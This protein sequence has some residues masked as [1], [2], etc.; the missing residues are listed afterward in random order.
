MNILVIGLGVIGSIYGYAFA[1]AGHTVTHYLRKDSKKNAINAL[2]IN[3]LDG[4]THKKGLSYTDTYPIGHATQKEYD[5]IFVAVPSGKLG[6]VI[7]ELNREGITG[8]LLIACGIWEERAEVKKILGNRPYVLGYPVA[9]GNLQ[10]KTL[11]ACLFDHFMLE[12][13]AKAGIPNYDDLAKLFASCQIQLEHPYDM[14][15]WIWLHIAINAG[16]ISVASTAI[17]SYTNN[18]QTTQAAEKLMQST[19][20]LRQS[21]RSIRETVKIV[22]SRGVVLK[23]YNN[24]LLPYKIPTFL[25]APLMKRM[26][27]RNILTQKIMTLHNNLPDLLY[28]CRCVYEQGKQNNIPA[29]LFY[30]NYEKVK[31]QLNF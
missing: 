19:P 31:A 24:E 5:F 11:N 9:G 26:F 25:S 22:A 3:M 7:Q 28:V 14:L 6:S 13:K 29:P 20:L 12:G 30:A 23:H 4:R 15:E 8:S 10:G 2:N 21:V 18:T 17:D 16:V 27:A 1:K